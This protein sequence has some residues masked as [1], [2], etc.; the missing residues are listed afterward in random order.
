MLEQTFC[1]LSGIGE[2]TERRLWERGVTSWD[3]LAD[4]APGTAGRNTALWRDELSLSRERLAAGDA[5]FFSD[6]LRPGDTWR[7]FPAFQG[8]VA[9]VDIET[10]GGP[11]QI[12]TAVALYDGQNA[13]TY[14]RGRN[15]DDFAAD[16]A[17]YP[18]IVT[19]NGR[20]FDVPVLTRNLGIS[21][22]QAHIDLRC[23]LGRLGIKGGLKSCE[24]RFGIGRG[25]LDGVD[26]YFAVILWQEYERTGDEA[27]LET[28]LAY[29]A[30]DVIGLETLLIHAVNACLLETPFAHLHSLPVPRPGHNPHQPDTSVLRRLAGRYL[31]GRPGGWR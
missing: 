10:D 13:R 19:Y 30:A 31:G 28:L 18:V 5:A 4:T 29:N 25:D 20:C 17:R 21:L 11:Q 26:G 24:K 1:H 12:V 6:R 16:I 15:L 8:K 22:P 7:I 9:Y 27:V 3:G 23:V 2:V 14:A